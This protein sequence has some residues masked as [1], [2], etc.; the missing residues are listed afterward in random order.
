M[1]AVPAGVVLARQSDRVSL[2][3]S[4]GSIV[5]AVLAGIAA[6]VLA[7]R[8]RDV[9]AITLGRAGGEQAA[10]LGRALGMLG[11]LVAVTAALAVGFYGLLTL[12]AG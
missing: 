6:I 1:A 11:L 4:S 2:L 8:A 7:R 9:L 12:F 5:V 10:R 3:Q